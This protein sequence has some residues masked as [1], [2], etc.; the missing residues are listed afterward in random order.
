MNRIAVLVL[1]AIAVG[2]SAQ[3]QTSTKRIPGYRCMMLDITEQQSMDPT[4]HVTLR[5]A[6]SPSSPE[7]GWA[8]SVV[9]VKEPVQSQN[10][11]L[12]MLK[13]NGQTAW[14]LANEVKAYHPVAAPNAKCVPEV[15]PNG[16][17]GT[18]PG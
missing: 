3:A 6:P 10:G 16:R 12:Q 15:L 1:T 9:I 14:I 4:F 13:P 5:A 2:M 18:G 17:V 11:F 8:G 7:A